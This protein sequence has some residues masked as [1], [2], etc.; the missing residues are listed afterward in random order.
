MQA[1]RAL[2][3]LYLTAIMSMLVS[4]VVF[5]A[6]GAGTTISES[7]C[8]IVGDI[9][10]IIGILAL[11]LFIAGGTMYAVA[12]MLPA[13]GNM[14]GNLQGWSMGMI[15]GGV[16][17]LILVVIAPSLLSAIAATASGGST[18]AITGCSTL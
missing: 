16:V 8:S 5:A 15:L 18:L 14:R 2:K 4:S 17:G 7:L 12:H 6:T 3:L 9:T 13:A 11:L 10:S 1:I